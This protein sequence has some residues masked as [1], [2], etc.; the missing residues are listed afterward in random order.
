[1]R[2]THKEK[3]LFPPNALNVN[4]IVDLTLL[5]GSKMTLTMMAIII[6]HCRAPALVVV[7][8]GQSVAANG[9]INGDGYSSDSCASYFS[10]ARMNNEA[11]P[12]PPSPFS[13]LFRSKRYIPPSGS[14]GNGW[15][16]CVPVRVAHCPGCCLP[17]EDQGEL[18]GGQ[19]RR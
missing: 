11:L 14:V 10:S 2:R 15:P 13:I 16:G 1:M 19:K 8:R 7:Q 3:E 17:Q 18:R 9:Q 5:L 4:P 6:L 12:P